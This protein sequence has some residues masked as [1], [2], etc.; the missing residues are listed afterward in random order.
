M[1]CF[2][3]ILYLLL[4]TTSF[5]LAAWS[6][7]ELYVGGELDA[8]VLSGS[9]FSNNVLVQKAYSPTL[10]GQIN[11]GIRFF[12]LFTIE[13]G[14]GQHWGRA[15]LG[16]EDFSREVEDFSIDINN[17][18][19]YWNYFFAVSTSYKIGKTD[20]Y[21]YGKLAVS[22]QNYGG[23]S[24]SETSSINISSLNIDRN[25]EYTTAFEENNYS[26]IPEIG[27]QQK[28]YKGNL[29]SIGLRYNIGQSEAYQ[30]SYSV[31][32]NG[33]DEL[34]S[35][36]LS[37]NGN[38]I[39][40]SLRYDFR[41]LHFNKKEKV[42]KLDLDKIAIDVSKKEDT[43]VSPP[44][45]DREQVITDRIKVKSKKVII[46]IWDHQTVD[47]DRVSLML[48]NKWILED[49][50]LTKEKYE[51]EVELLEG[52]NTFVLHALN[53]GDIKPNTAALWVDDGVKKHRIILQSNMKKSGTLQ[54]KV[55]E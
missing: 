48:N 38:S 22:F 7:A 21:L 49:H 8:G 5:P 35:D 1:H 19:Y 15:R 52:V 42:K 26:F 17:S 10:G 20:S 45:M 41:L 30:S 50:S 28:F 6:Q 34:S 2:R 3:K 24:A 4:I 40:L 13:T 39:S 25:L 27:F 33:G 36:Q 47:G 9:E 14:I 31:T 46:S 37:S 44:A 51:M 53:L 43:V 11:L 16:D 23:G 18:Y 32:N 55:K 54:I 12:D 29:L